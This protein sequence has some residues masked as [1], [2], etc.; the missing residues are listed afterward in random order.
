MQ[1]F[2][3]SIA[4]NPYMPHG[5]IGI[6]MCLDFLDRKAEAWPYFRKAVLLDPNNYY[7]LAPYGWHFIQYQAWWPAVR[8]LSFSLGLQ[9]KNN[10]MARSYFDIAQRKI[11]EQ[12]SP[13]QI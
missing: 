6:G 3:K 12:N 11:A 2:Q 13:P 7:V 8:K 10:S 5:Y 1:W 4:L 9:P